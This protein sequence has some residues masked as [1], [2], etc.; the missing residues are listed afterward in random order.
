MLASSNDTIQLLTKFWSFHRKLYFNENPKQN[1][2]I[3]DQKLSLIKNQ[4]IISDVEIPLYISSCFFL[5][6]QPSH[7]KIWIKHT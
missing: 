6:L 2:L 7:K 4:N 5:W 1:T 3:E